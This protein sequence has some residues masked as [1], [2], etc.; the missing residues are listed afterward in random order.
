MERIVLK[1]LNG[2]KTD[3]EERFPLSEFKEI[4]LGRDPS[5]T[6]RFSDESE[7][8]VGRQH[9]RVTRNIALPSQFFITDLNSR[10]GTFVNGRRIVGRVDLKPGDVVQCGVGGPQLRFMIEP[11]TSP[12][13]AEMAAPTA[14]LLEFARAQPPRPGLPLPASSV[15]P[16]GAAVAPAREPR[17]DQSKASAGVLSRKPLIVGGGILI[18]LVALVAGAVLYRSI[19]SS[20]SSEVGQ[21]GA[22]PKR[23]AQPNAVAGKYDHVHL[24]GEDTAEVEK[25]A[26]RAAWRI[27]VAP[28][29]ALGSGHPGKA[30]SDFDKPD[31]VAF[32]NTG[33]LYATD[34]K[35]R[36]VQVWDVKT[37]SHLAEFGHGVFG[38]EIVD[39][40]ITPDNTVL[41]TDQTLN[42]AYVFAPPQ[43]GALDEKG[44]PLGPYDYQFKGT[45]LGEQGFKKLGGIA[46]DSRGHI[47]AVD[48]HRNE[49]YRFNSDGKPDKTWKFEKTRGDGDTY[50]HG[51]EG[52]AIDE[53]AGNLFIA[54]E[55]DAVIEVFDWETGGYKH[56]VVGAGNDNSDHP[57]GK[58]VFFGSV[59]GLAIAQHHLLAVDESAGHI[60]IF[61]LDRPDAFNT[62]LAG[63]AAPRPT[64]P[65]GYQGFIGH[66]PLVDFEDKTNLELQKQV[67]T[68]SIIPGQSNPPGYFCSPDSI[69]SY[70]DQASGESYIAIADQCNYR[71]VVYRWSD[72]AKAMGVA[73]PIR[74]TTPVVN[75]AESE[76]KAAHPVVNKNAGAAGSRNTAPGVARVTG[77][78]AGKV[79]G[80]GGGKGGGAVAV[81]SKGA[82]MAHSVNDAAISGKK[83]KK[84][85]KAKTNL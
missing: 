77:A 6:V 50:L 31:G 72:I 32:S 64:R 66:A 18:V 37:G 25:D 48:A 24:S 65:T 41:I 16:V 79:A 63:Y 76:S 21:A 49:V 81:T 75:K 26:E 7:N 27:E 11:E 22:T 17:V 80:A 29:L 54:S 73:A 36:R 57:A 33:L 52:I 78:S 53:A 67:K 8:M 19:G 1:H 3:Q 45:R 20:S 71:I 43:P 74:R 5:S 84:A 69:A 60:Q 13:T 28:Y 47:F 23:G 14:D 30:D 55:K 51:C 44:K 35:N 56:E 40:A 82:G 39:I 68:G 62:D 61:N 83:A 70:T 10:N 46:V 4:I 34:A 38:G 12:L 2:S 59:E 9:A 85:K 15:S 58:H 42:L